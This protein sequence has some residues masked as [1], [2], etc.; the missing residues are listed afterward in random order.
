MISIVEKIFNEKNYYDS[1]AV[2]SCLFWAGHSKYGSING[3]NAARIGS[4]S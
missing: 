2:L 3:A 1:Y 4:C